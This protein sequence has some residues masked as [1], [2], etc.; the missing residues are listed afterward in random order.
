VRGVEDLPTE[1][2]SVGMGISRAGDVGADVVLER[3]V[4]SD[5]GIEFDADGLPGNTQ[6]GFPLH[7]ACSLRTPVFDIQLLNS[8]V[9]I[10]RIACV[11]VGRETG[12]QAHGSVI[13]VQAPTKE[14][15]A[16]S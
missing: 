16:W 12:L 15:I 4:I 6:S 13:H 11:L 5:D 2:P 7:G 9:Q 8:E 10:I 3:C 14:V 1:M